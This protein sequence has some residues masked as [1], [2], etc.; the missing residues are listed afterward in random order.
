MV[1]CCRYCVL[2]FCC[3]FNLRVWCRCGL[4]SCLGVVRCVPFFVG[5]GYCGSF[6]LLSFLVWFV[7]F[8]FV[9]FFVALFCCGLLLCVFVWCCYCGYSL[10]GFV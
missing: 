10:F 7:A 8:V 1:G 9:C 5:C 3:L 2:M 6:L 4:A